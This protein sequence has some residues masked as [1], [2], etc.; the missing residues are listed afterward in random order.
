M[1]MALI[2][3]INTAYRWI[4]KTSWLLIM[5]FI[6]DIIY[7]HVTGRISY[8]LKRLLHEVFGFAPAIILTIFFC[9]VKKLST[10]GR[11]APKNYSIFYKIN[12][13]C[14]LNWFECVNV[15][16]MQLKRYAQTRNKLFKTS[17]SLPKY[18]PTRCVHKTGI[19]ILEQLELKEKSFDC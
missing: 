3:C 8:C 4:W 18:E 1:K 19:N 12:M 16:V 7:W 5:N 11:V 10:V 13:V 2:P 6:K 15:I 9:K 17:L 14:I